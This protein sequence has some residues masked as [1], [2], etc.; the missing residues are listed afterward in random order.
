MVCLVNDEQWCLLKSRLF[1]IFLCLGFQPFR[2]NTNYNDKGFGTACFQNKTIP[3][4]SASFREELTR[5]H[6]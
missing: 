2:P 4:P 1:R 3:L 5:K 6:P